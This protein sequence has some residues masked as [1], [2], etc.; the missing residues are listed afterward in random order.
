MPPALPPQIR[1]PLPPRLEW[2]NVRE[3]RPMCLQPLRARRFLP[4]RGLTLRL[5]LPARL[6]GA[7][8]PRRRGRVRRQPLPQWGL[9]RQRAGLVCV[10]MPRCLHWPPLRDGVRALRPVALPQRGHLPAD[11]RHGLRLLLPASRAVPS[12][13]LAAGFEGRDCD[14]NV[15]DCPGNRCDN[16]A[17]CV[18]GVNTYNCQC[19]P[20]WT[21]QYCTEDVD[22]CQLQPNA[23]LNGGTCHNTH[24]GY[25]CVC[26]NGWT[27][28]DC[29]ENIDDCA[30]AACFNGATCHDR[31][32][33][34]FCQCPLGKTGL[35]CHLDDACVSDPCHEGAICDTNPINGKA[36]CT[37]RAGFTGGACNQDVDE[38]SIG[39]NPCEH[40]GRCINTQGS[41]RCQCTAGF[42]GPR[43]E[44]DINECNSMPCLNDATCLDKIGEFTCICM[45]GFEG[46]HC[47]ID[48]NECQSGPC[49]NDGN[50]TDHVNGF[51]C[52]CPPGFTGPMCQIDMDECASTPCL[53]GAKCV[54]RPNAYSCECTEG[55]AGLVCEL[56]VNECQPD[57]CHHGKCVDGIASFYCVCSPGYT[58]FLCDSQLN[59]CQS[60]PCQNGGKCVDLVNR[61]HCQCLEGTEGVNCETNFD[62]CAGEL[63]QRGKCVD[64]VNEYRCLCDAGYTGLQCDVEL[65]ECE[66]SPCHNGGSCKDL[67]DAFECVCLPG[68]HGPLC[69]SETD[70][71]YASPCL[72]GT[73]LDHGESY[74]CAC[75]AGWT[76][77]L[78][79][80][81]IDECE[82]SPCQNG[83]ACQEHLDGYTCRCRD[84]FKGPTCQKNVNECVSNP[85]LNR[86][87]CVD[88]VAGYTC[89]CTLPFT[90]RNCE[91]V[92][93]PCASQPCHNAATCKE[94]VNLSSFSCACPPGWRG[95]T[96][97]LDID[98]CA[99]APCQHG[100]ACMNTQGGFR[101]SCRPGYTGPTCQ[102]DIDDCSPN[103]CQ[104]GGSCTDG[105]GAFSCKCRPGFRGSRCETEVNECASNPCRNGGSCADYVN[106]YTCRCRPGFNG[107][108]CEH[109]ITECTD[110]SCLNG[111]SCVDGINAYTCLCRGGFTGSYCQ[112]DIDECESQPCQH[113]GTC[114]DGLGTYKCTCPRGYTGGNCQALVDW[115]SSSPCKNSGSCVQSRTSYRC[116]CHSG[117]T[118]L[119]CDIPNMSC[120]TAARN[121]G[122]SVSHLCRHGGRCIDAGNTHHCQCSRGFEGSYCEKEVDECT[123]NPCHN[124]ATCRNFLGSYKCEC[125]VGYHGLNCDYEINECLSQ[126]CQNGGK[127]IDLVNR[128][129]CVC[130][131]GT[132]GILCEINTDDCN[133]GPDA[134][135]PGPRCF[136]GGSC[137]DGVGSF[138][139]SCPPGFVGERCEGDV[140]ECLS[141]PCDPRGSLDCI[142]LVNDYKCQ[143]RPGFTGH[144]C[145][146]VINTCRLEPCRNGGTCMITV[147][148]L[149]GF[150]CLC[151]PGY[152]GHA[153]EDNAYACGNLS[154][155]N[156][157]TCLPDRAAGPLCVCPRAWRGPECQ[158]HSG[159]GGGSSACA[160]SPCENGAACY[161]EVR[162]P[163]YRC[164]C[165]PLFTGPRCRVLG[166]KVPGDAS[167]GR[168]LPVPPP[169]LEESCP[170]AE[171][172][173]HAGDGLCDRDCNNHACAWDGGDCS[174]H[175]PSPWRNCSVR[176]QCWLRFRNGECDEQCNSLGCLF[177]GFDCQ[178]GM[179]NCNPLYNAYCTAHYA[180]QHCDQGC[181]SDECGWDGGDCAGEVP[182]RLADGVLVLIMLLPPARVHN[183]SA[184]FLRQ[185]GSL[186]HATVRFKIDTNG[187]DM[188]FP[189]YGD[190]ARGGGGPRLERAARSL[191]RFVR[192][193]ERPLIGSKV[194]V[195]IDNRHCYQTS[196]RCFSSAADAAAFLAAQAT[197]GSLPLPLLGV[198][199]EV[200]DVVTAPR[201]QVYVLLGLVLLVLMV[202]V[203]LG[204]L[205]G[206]KR[207]RE[208]GTLWFPEG[209]I[210]GPPSDKKKRREPVGQ[211]DVG[212][213]T[214]SQSS[215]E[216]S[217]IDGNQNEAWLDGSVPS[218]KRRKLEEQGMLP[219][220]EEPV[221]HRPWT[222]QHLEAADIRTAPALVLALTPPQGEAD[223]GMDVN[224]RGPNGF[225]PLMVASFH[226]G[227]LDSSLCDEEESSDGLFED[228]TDDG[229]ANV[230]T[231]L[232]CQ[233]AALHAQTDRTGETAL[234]LAARYARS[235]AAKRL[236][237]AGADANLPD[238]MGR[239]PLHAAVSA[240]AQGVFQILIRNRATDVDARMH[241]GTTPLI[242]AARLAVEGM[243][244]ELINCHADVNKVDD[245]GKSAL[246]WAAA[247]NNVEATL[248]LLKNGANK[249]MQDNKE[250]TPLFLAAREGSYETAKLLLDHFAS[251]DITDHVDRLPRDIAQERL[252]HDIVRLLDEYNV[253]RNPSGPNGLAS[254]PQ[255]NG[256]YAHGAKAGKKGVRRPGNKSGVAHDAAKCKKAQKKVNGGVASGGGGDGAPLLGLDGSASLSPVNSE[257]SQSDGTSPSL[258]T[259][260]HVAHSLYASMEAVGCGPPR[261]G[262]PMAFR[263][264]AIAVASG[265]IN[266]MQNVPLSQFTH[267]GHSLGLT[268]SHPQSNHRA[269]MS[270][271]H[272]AM[273]NNQHHQM[274]AFQQNLY[275]PRNKPLMEAPQHH[276]EQARGG[277]FFQ[278]KMPMIQPQSNLQAASQQSQLLASVSQSNMF[279]S[280]QQQHQ[281]IAVPMQSFVGSEFGESFASNDYKPNEKSHSQTSCVLTQT[282][283]PPQEANPSVQSSQLAKREGAA[284][285]EQFPTP[286]SQ[287]SRGEGSPGH[288]PPPGTPGEHPYLTPSPETPERWSTCSPRS[289]A[290]DWSDGVSS[291]PGLAARAQRRPADPQQQLHNLQALM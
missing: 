28:E 271:L 168:A 41:F 181:N 175:F 197:H 3:G 80:V 77:P 164:V 74:R 51:L 178:L 9:L 217:L 99:G 201:V 204:V 269:M 177:D 268:S 220:A 47:E 33:S 100:G 265:W 115:C 211:D 48:I 160:S 40:G 173:S 20:Q 221:D 222:Q 291:P 83:G 108:H 13:R 27:G 12:R 246:H 91:A 111:G 262:H 208:Q 56:N 189:Y 257:S 151:A 55:F 186:L 263:N 253:V 196:D 49:L 241:D 45:P 238:N 193:M 21:G 89:L 32:A 198:S 248:V 66:S 195:E 46:R 249:D 287:H 156:G 205:V 172:E 216:D 79:E 134:P 281:G 273:I 129:N 280:L 17:T 118:G 256:A 16:G 70:A 282:V 58:G 95:A 150:T 286:P 285:A 135:M 1:V 10:R 106:S 169:V 213:K 149:L 62:D 90:G 43:C 105:V 165:P 85:C 36:I 127:C 102:T 26:V 236:L 113:G 52:R 98:E 97:S 274:L 226:G 30:I 54:D 4:C 107:I 239:S 277:A 230:I 64:G 261:V 23:C 19:S 7:H 119:Y 255:A 171:C 146:V 81:D 50:C 223:D 187:Q 188:I 25:N 167:S 138:T 65:N 272:P 254:P 284:P 112:F 209:F 183:D 123:S 148:T 245:L 231:D 57:P 225:T 126:P 250:E 31:V 289:G 232:I 104:N 162:P 240:D 279:P 264:G 276:P 125:P 206:R 44:T 243:A 288:A 84:G 34:F 78:C 94:S 130:P 59:E 114:L 154:C 133:P 128:F 132:Q 139:C 69:Y 140:N 109:D 267:Q 117:W 161:E 158:Y 202:V 63:C 2:Q 101:C 143:C 199:S 163:F 185:L 247:V 142:Q 147:N 18:D 244:E 200:P 214:L 228:G 6:L 37:C 121:K 212:M 75:E 278:S 145:E 131:P 136:N 86:G 87:T 88:G 11:G 73:C 266:P 137:V 120:D 5:R 176:L 192:E 124:G 157:G 275:S 152:A 24:G 215:V 110:S 122:L 96:C 170:V 61:Y 71:C 218:T 166:P 68:F 8:V 116:D 229:S 153:C 92:M 190:E 194:Y 260:P 53:N 35:L 144:N 203:L 67:V 207:R 38:C 235:D 242:L 155:R 258:L 227:G 184:N 283:P 76:G 15:D 270:P 42:T 180:D 251:R 103:P 237:D 210:L 72:H 29:S 224:V 93:A 141:N 252:H 82:S 219:E 182:E 233:G 191:S 60:S 290:S 159:G 234:H 174:L 22:E 14:V 39:A 179:K 259:S